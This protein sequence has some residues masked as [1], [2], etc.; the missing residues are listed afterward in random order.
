MPY[1]F[2]VWTDENTQHLAEHAVTRDEFEQVV[3]DPETTD[4][5]RTSDNEIAFGFTSEGR[6]LACVYYFHDEM[7]VVPVTAYEPNEE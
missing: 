6:F 5:S 2:F 4:R 7:T 1:Y 3:G